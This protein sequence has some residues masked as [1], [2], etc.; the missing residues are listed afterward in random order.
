[1]ETGVV[2][3][4]IRCRRGVRGL[5]GVGA[6]SG[7]QIRAIR[8]GRWGLRVATVPPLRDPARQ[9]TARKKKLSLQSG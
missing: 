8:R 4:R 1:V 5:G 7:E 9:K 2:A 3:M 6:A